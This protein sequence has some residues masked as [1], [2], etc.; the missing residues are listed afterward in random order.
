MIALPYCMLM[1]SSVVTSTAP[2]AP[3]HVYISR[4]VI[5]LTMGE[6]SNPSKKLQGGAA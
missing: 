1:L 2:A 4:V 6:I 3:E 5:T